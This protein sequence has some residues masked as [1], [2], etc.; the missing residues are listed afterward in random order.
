LRLEDKY[1]PT[2]VLVDGLRELV[3]CGRDL[4]S[5]EKDSLLTLDANVFGPS[6][7]ASEVSLWLDVTSNSKVAR[8]LLE[9]GA[10]YLV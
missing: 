7:K 9:Q 8:S 5:L 10:L 2:L 3:N 1:S 6:D 4:Q